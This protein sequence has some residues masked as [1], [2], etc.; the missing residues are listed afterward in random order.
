M[1]ALLCVLA[2]AAILAAADDGLTV[3]SWDCGAFADGAV[4]PVSV[5]QPL[6]GEGVVATIDGHRMLSVEHGQCL[7]APLE[8]GPLASGKPVAIEIEFTA[9]ALPDGYHGGLI[10]AGSYSDSGVRIMYQHDQRISVEHFTGKDPV[11]LVSPEPV[12]LGR[13]TTLRYEYD[14]AR[15]RLLLDGKVVVQTDCPPAAAWRG[16]LRVGVASGDKYNFNGAIGKL[17]ILAIPAGH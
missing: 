14:G 5:G 2:L 1:R 13:F 10:E 12:A 17:R 3:A 6:K 11:Y 9:V 15:A 4:P 8:N 16:S 7:T